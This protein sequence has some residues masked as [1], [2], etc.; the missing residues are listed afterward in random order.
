MP[1]LYALTVVLY[2][3]SGLLVA[4]A[5][6]HWRKFARSNRAVSARTFRKTARLTAIALAMLGGT[7]LCDLLVGVLP[8]GWAAISPDDTGATP[9]ASVTVHL[10]E[11]KPVIE[12]AL[13]AESYRLTGDCGSGLA[14][15]CA[16]AGRIA[17]VLESRGFC[18][19][20]ASRHWEKSPACAQII[21]KP[22][23]ALGLPIAGSVD[24]GPQ[25][26]P[27]SWQRR[28]RTAW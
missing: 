11:A 7:L 26:S 5:A 4:A 12:A 21:G 13:I 22:D 24:T 23:L 10:D 15:A 27:R 6:W 1:I 18:R 14:S 17:S 16:P 20:N 8:S 9:N 28:K 25:P 2:I 19:P 3:A